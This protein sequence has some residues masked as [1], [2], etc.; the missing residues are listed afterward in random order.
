MS[1]RVHSWMA[2]LLLLAPCAAAAPVRVS[3]LDTDAA[4]EDT[5]QIL[6][7]AGCDP[8]NLAAIR[9]AVLHYYRTPLA[10]DLAAFPPASDGFHEFASSGD[11]VDTLGT[12]SLAYLDHAFELNCLD[13]ALLLTGPDMELTADLQTRG[14]PFFAIQVH[15][16]SHEGLVPV[17]SL[18]EV[19]ATAHPPG[20][21][22]FM[23]ET[24]GFEFSEKH[25]TL[26]SVFY[27]YQALPFDTVANTISNE[28]RAALRRHWQRCGI[29]FPDKVALIMLHRASTLFHLVVTDHMG[30]LVKREA[31]YLYLEKTGGRGPFLRIDVQ[32][33]ADLAP[34]FSTMTFPNYPF[35]FLS[36]NDDFFLDVPPRPGSST[37][38]SINSD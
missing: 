21:K 27:Q 4:R 11:F 6:A 23:A 30:V 10:L 16:G 3:F 33:P 29:R 9:K 32:D 12:N 7:D 31:G 19:Y 13:A 14:D 15:P 36:V 20:A 25:R 34:Y 1:R 37:S 17:T 28:T 2:G 24:F 35:N 22:R 26:E 18:G 38:N 5:L 8:E